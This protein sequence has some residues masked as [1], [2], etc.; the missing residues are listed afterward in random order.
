MAAGGEYVSGPGLPEAVALLNLLVVVALIF[1]A[2][3][4]G[5]K[6]AIAKRSE[7]ISKNLTAAREELIAVEARLKKAKAEY[8]DLASKKQEVLESVRLEGERVAKQILEETKVS[9]DQIL[10]DAELSAK[11]EV[12][13]AAKK[14][15]ANLVEQTFA[16][17]FGQLEGSTA[18]A[19]EQKT[20]IHD[21]LFEK[22]VN[23][24]PSQLNSSG[25]LR[26]GT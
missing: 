11:S 3:R 14:I 6:S 23:E 18:Q 8:D 26:N 20:V 5:I 7:D 1:F 4:K 15:R 19:H 21:K 10:A 25:G 24:I 9:A 2:G 22:L 17:T 12:N 13:N 16:Q